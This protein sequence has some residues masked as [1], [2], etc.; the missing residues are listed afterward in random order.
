MQHKHNNN[1]WLAFERGFCILY[2]RKIIA[3]IQYVFFLILGQY[4][5][6]CIDRGEIWPK[7]TEIR[8][9]REYKTAN[10]FDKEIGDAD[11]D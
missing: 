6:W 5:I 4:F 11:T 9:D 10:V 2:M 3:I 8:P 1:E 7:T